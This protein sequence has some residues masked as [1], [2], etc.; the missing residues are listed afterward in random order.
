MLYSKS[1]CAR[2]WSKLFK[3]VNPINHYHPVPPGD[4]SNLPHVAW[5]MLELDG[6]G[7]RA[8]E[9]ASEHYPGS[10]LFLGAGPRDGGRWGTVAG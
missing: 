10:L 3:G 4:V 5:L 2:D 6:G 1:L 9:P 7:G 8:P